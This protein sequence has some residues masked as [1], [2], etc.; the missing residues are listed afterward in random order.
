MVPRLRARALQT[1]RDRGI[2]IET[3]HEFREA[4]F[5]KVFQPARYGGYE[6]PV[7]FMVEVCAELGRGCGSS[8]WVFSNLAG[9][10][11]IVGTH[12]PRAQDEVWAEHPDNLVASSFPTGGGTARRVDG[13]I[14]VNGLYSFASGVDFA[15]WENLQVFIPNEGRAPDHRFALVPKA[16]YTIK[17]DWYSTGLSGTGSRSVMLDNV[18]IPEHRLLDVQK[19][20][21]AEDPVVDFH[22]N[23]LYRL[24]PMSGA[25]KFFPGPAIGIARGAL[26]LIEEELRTR[27]NVGGL[28][29]AELP[30]A[31][32]RIAEAGAEIDAAYALMLQDSA[33]AMRYAALGYRAPV[34]ARARWRRDNAFAGQLCLRAV[35]RLHPLSGGRGLHRDSLFQ[36]TW[37]DIHAAVQQITMAWDIQSVNSGRV[38]VGLPSLDPRL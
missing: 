21:N 36:L 2:P 22:P 34:T 19:V 25:A 26:E 13:G 28:L 7:G 14:I 24:H 29:M 27:R 30:T 15:Q 10:S 12:S 31:Q 37:R 1:D 18:F 11:T 33:E 5:Y 6:M 17:D 16:D 38:Q 32:A 8:A 9:Q 23:P 20:G 35:E 3:H 4:G